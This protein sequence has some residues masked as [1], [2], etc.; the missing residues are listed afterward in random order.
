VAPLYG[1]R[2]TSSS[3]AW[4]DLAPTIDAS[5]LLPLPALM[6]L[7]AGPREPQPSRRGAAYL[8]QLF[9]VH[10]AASHGA[11]TLPPPPPI[12]GTV[13]ERLQTATRAPACAGCHDEIDGFGEMFDHFDAVGAYR[14]AEQGRTIVGSARLGVTGQQLTF[15]GVR[16][17]VRELTA[18]PALATL[19]DR[20]HAAHWLTFATGRAVTTADPADADAIQ[21]Y[22][23]ASAS[24]HLRPRATIAAVTETRSFWL[25]R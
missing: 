13:R 24:G 8:T 10:R 20:C 17:L 23:A 3:F 16:G 11:M 5:A 7:G 19:I 2:E 15:N 6:A 25:S 1:M 4:R 18:T 22:R 14:E 9:C 21:I 12:G